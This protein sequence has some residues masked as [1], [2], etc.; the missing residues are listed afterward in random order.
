MFTGEKGN[1]VEK[2]NNM[3]L[4]FRDTVVN[5]PIV[6]R[7]RL[8]KSYPLSPK[9]KADTVSQSPLLSIRG[10][11]IR[12][13]AEKTHDHYNVNIILYPLTLCSGRSFSLSPYS[14]F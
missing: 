12:Q 13:V 11:L 6:R 10:D 7:R 5:R 9:G 1:D 2:H 8:A 14:F 3:I 4:Q